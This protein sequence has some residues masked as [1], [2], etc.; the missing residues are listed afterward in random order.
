MPVQLQTHLAVF[1]FVIQGWD[2]ANC[3]S[4]WP[5]GSCLVLPRGG[6]RGRLESWRRGERICSFLLTC[7]FRQ[8]RPSIRPLCP[9]A[10]VSCL[11]LPLALPGP[12]S[13][14]PIRGPPTTQAVPPPW[15]SESPPCRAP[16][17]HSWGTS[18][19]RTHPYLRAL[20]TGAPP[21]APSPLRSGSQ[22]CRVPVY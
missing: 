8:C 4:P 6:A 20:S 15:K 18:S 21:S 13:L 17:L 12:T 14:H 1:C 22:L 5:A 19:S 2:A 11:Q 10:A 16:S 7:C 3:L 9:A